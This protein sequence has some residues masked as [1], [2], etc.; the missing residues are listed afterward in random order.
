MTSTTKMASIAGGTACGPAE[1]LSIRPEE[2]HFSCPSPGRMPTVSWQ[3]PGRSAGTAYVVN[4]APPRGRAVLQRLQRCH[5]RGDRPRRRVPVRRRESSI[6]SAR[7]VAGPF[8][9]WCASATTVHSTSRPARAARADECGDR[10]ARIRR[11]PGSRAQ[12]SL[13]H[14]RRRL[15]PPLTLHMHQDAPSDKTPAGCRVVAPP[16]PNQNSPR[17]PDRRSPAGH[18]DHDQTSAPEA[19]QRPGEIGPPLY[20]ARTARRMR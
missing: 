9:A 20:Q 12:R 6:R 4:P 13:R 2:C 18:Q 8:T 16:T 14:R 5:R 19:D 15:L 10:L 7:P 11:P 1:G 3:G 17:P